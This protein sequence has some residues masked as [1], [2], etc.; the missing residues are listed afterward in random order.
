MQPRDGHADLPGFGLL[1]WA[2]A[3]RLAGVFD[4]PVQ[5]VLAA[6]VKRFQGETES[7]ISLSG[8]AIGYA[9]FVLRSAFSTGFEHFSVFE[10]SFV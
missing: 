2:V 8:V 6:S 7:L 5:L 1:L 10:N 4:H 3:P 9:L